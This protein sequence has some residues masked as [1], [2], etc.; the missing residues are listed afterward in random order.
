L[1]EM[2][3]KLRQQKGKVLAKGKFSPAAKSPLAYI[4]GAA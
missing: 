3:A 4:Q 2:R 1:D